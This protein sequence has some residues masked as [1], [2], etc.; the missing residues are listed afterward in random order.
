MACGV[1][2][3][4]VSAE[5]VHVAAPELTVT[6]ELQAA[7]APPLSVNA[8][9]PEMATETVPEVGATVAVNVTD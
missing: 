7:I 2:A 4:A 6:G 1:P 9:V 5:V 8:T 3:V